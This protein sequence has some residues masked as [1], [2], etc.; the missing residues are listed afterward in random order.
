[1]LRYTPMVTVTMYVYTDKPDF[2]AEMVRYVPEE[3]NGLFFIGNRLEGVH[4]L[5]VLPRIED[6][7]LVAKF[8]VECAFGDTKEAPINVNQPAKHD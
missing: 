4:G 3:N 1:M 7:P 2:D 5:E 6:R 8:T